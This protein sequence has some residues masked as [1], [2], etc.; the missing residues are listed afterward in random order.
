MEDNLTPEVLARI[1]RAARL[2]LLA[3]WEDASGADAATCDAAVDLATE[4]GYPDDW[5]AL[6]DTARVERVREGT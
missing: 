6:L 4:L 1:C 5:D 3:W 2:F